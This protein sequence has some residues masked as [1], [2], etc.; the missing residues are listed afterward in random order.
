MNLRRSN[1][2]SLR[3]LLA[4]LNLVAHLY[5]RGPRVIAATVAEM[6]Y[7]AFTQLGQAGPP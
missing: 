3:T 6:L 7:A 1:W 4:V 5:Q 2:A